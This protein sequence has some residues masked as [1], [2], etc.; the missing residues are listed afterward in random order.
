M[1]DSPLAP[2]HLRDFERLHALI[3]AGPEAA[4]PLLGELFTWLQDINWP[5]ALPMAN[6][7]ISVGAPIVPHIR[8]VLA[9]GDD[10]WIYWVL[11]HVVAVLPNHL[12]KELE[13]MLKAHATAAEND[14]VALRIG[15]NAGIWNSAL[16]RQL[17]AR[18]IAACEEFIAELK[19]LQLELP[20]ILD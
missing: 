14:V 9:S 18:K 15:C 6:F 16:Q 8:K 20:V 12:V 11:Q 2:R 5:I 4:I 17:L 1:T 3:E 19:T 7:L 13:P 10:M